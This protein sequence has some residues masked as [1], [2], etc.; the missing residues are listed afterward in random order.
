MEPNIM[1]RNSRRMKSVRYVTC[2]GAMEKKYA[3]NISI[4]NLEGKGPVERSGCRW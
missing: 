3:H 4:E 2:M 1:R